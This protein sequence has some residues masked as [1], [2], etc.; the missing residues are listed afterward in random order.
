MSNEKDN[1]LIVTCQVSIVNNQSF[2]NAYTVLFGV[3]DCS[4]MLSIIRSDK[5]VRHFKS[6]RFPVVVIHQKYDSK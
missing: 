6:Y 4:L 1:Q 5:E 2:I 3:K